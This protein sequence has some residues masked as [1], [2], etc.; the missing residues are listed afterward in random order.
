MATVTTLATAV[1]TKSQWQ[2][3]PG[4]RSVWDY[5]PRGELQ[6]RMLTNI[7][8]KLSGN[9]SEYIATLPLPRNFVYRVSATF[10]WCRSDD[11]ADMDDFEK[12]MQG[13]ATEGNGFN[14]FFSLVNSSEEST[15]LAA[16]RINDTGKAFQTSFIPTY[17]RAPL[18]NCGDGAGSLAYTW[19]NSS[20]NATGEVRFQ[21]LVKVLIYDVNQ[22]LHAAMHSP[23]PTVSAP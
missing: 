10:I 17:Q 23:L 14:H 19:W 9:S 15:A 11:V 13:T 20:G 16:Y 18:I 2:I 6:F 3:A 21:M 12:M 5:Q 1:T 22:A 4:D 8:T 7:P